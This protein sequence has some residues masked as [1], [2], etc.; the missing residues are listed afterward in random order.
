MRLVRWV[1]LLLL[2]PSLAAA[3]SVTATT[4]SINGRVVDGSGA[5]LPGVT[6]TISSPSMQGTRTAATGDDGTYRFPAVPPGEYKITYEL[7]GFSTVIRERIRVTLGFTATVNSELAVASLQESVTVTG[8]S[9]VVDVT[10]TATSTNYDMEKLAALPNARDFW[11]VLA[12]APAIQVQRI[13]VGGSAA[14]TQTGY[15]AYDTKADQHRPMVEGIVNT[16]GTNAAGWYYDYG[17]VEEVSVGTATHGAEMPTP[18]V[19]SQFISKS[20]GNAYNGKIYAD[21]QNESIQARNIDDS[22]TALCPGGR[23]GN[24]TP[25]DLNRITGYHD[26][27]ADIGGYLK[28]DKL[29]WYFSA[30]DQNIKSLLPNFPV[31]PFETG[32]RNLTGKV[33]YALTT[34][35]KLVGYAG[36]GRKTQP[37]RLDTFRVSPL[38]ARHESEDSTWLQLYWGHTYKGEW[39]SVLSDNMF[40]E[41]RVGQFKY[42][43]PNKRYTDAPAYQDIVTN[44]VSGGNRDGWF[45]IPERNQWHGSLS[46]YKDNWAGSHNFKVGGE[47]LHETFT[48][49]RGAEGLGTVPGDVLH[50]LSNGVPAEVDFFQTPSIS[51]N[52]LWTMAGYIQD[53]WRVTNRLTLNLGVRVDRYRS[54][55]PEQEGP[56]VGPFNAVQINFP[57]QN[58]VFTWNLAA[59]R[60]GATFDLLGNG[61]TVFK[62]NWGQYWWNPG[63][64]VVENINQNSVDW[65]RRH[66]WNDVNGDRRWQPGEE[67]QLLQQFGGA[68]SS[69]LDPEMEDTRTDEF[70]VWLDHEL[71]P[72]FGVHGGYVYRRI[73]NFRALVNMNRPME[74]YDVPRTIRD[75]GPDNVLGNADDGGTFNVFN[76]NPA[77]LALPVVNLQTNG[78][79]TAE[80]HNFEISGTRRQTGWWSLSASFAM[81]WNKD[82]EDVYFGQRIRPVTADF[83]TNPNDLI[84]TDN[85]R[86]NF[87]TWSAKVNATIDAPWGFG[88]T[89]ALRHQSGQPYGRIFIPSGAQALNYGTQQILAEPMNTRRQDNIN[90]LDLRVERR[91]TLP[92][93]QRL[94]PFFDIY[95][96]TNSDAASNINWNSGATFELPATIIGPRIM[97][98]GVKYDW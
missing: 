25:S 17:S 77:N 53:T 36:G 44:V 72:N 42:E 88:L 62:V 23:C 3:Q 96:I 39:N 87:T 54:F 48:Y 37:N 49:I 82:V 91:I 65:R 20:G 98:F 40:F 29:W 8:E 81:R 2:V 24:L 45:N 80:Y 12:A 52:G 27:N 84:N 35:N 86:L 18:G 47:L 26:I 97:R 14:G 50:Y 71:M 38:I 67:G 85:G 73:G 10:A 63:T 5:V 58:D 57:A 79:G 9:P 46:Y 7:S 74:A 60:I 69:V 92:G 34:N 64:G 6:I 90:V 4:G 31:K 78:P 32:L 76:L 19:L 13:D 93:Q 75:P 21:Y 68:G 66:R 33:T 11:A 61:K 89:P 70:A 22:M 28:K 56:P 15:S 30:R 41:T 95:N 55:L 43:W 16:E 83:V 1:F 94:S 59:P 51:E